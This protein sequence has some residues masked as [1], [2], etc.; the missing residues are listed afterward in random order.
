MPAKA[1]RQS[2][3][4]GPCF[5]FGMTAG[6]LNR[7]FVSPRV[8]KARTYG[9]QEREPISVTWLHDG[10]SASKRGAA[11]WGRGTATISVRRPEMGS[12]RCNAKI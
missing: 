2:R 4:P 7:H 9:L 1:E 10:R 3:R 11:G 5:A 6:L 8:T 12:W